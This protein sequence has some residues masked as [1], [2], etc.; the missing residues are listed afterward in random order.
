MVW[1]VR[2]KCLRIAVE[3]EYVGIMQCSFSLVMAVVIAQCYYVFHET[4]WES[5]SKIIARHRNISPFYPLLPSLALAHSFSRHWGINLKQS[6]PCSVKN[7]PR[8]SIKRAK[9]MGFP[10]LCSE[11]SAL[12]S[13]TFAF[14]ETTISFLGACNISVH[15]LAA[16]SSEICT[17]Q[18]CKNMNG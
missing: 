8:S 6:I 13:E 17:R 3:R 16:T 7:W 1:P 18:R 11:K 2:R 12:S 14:F 15:A 9:N 5:A 10:P 4:S